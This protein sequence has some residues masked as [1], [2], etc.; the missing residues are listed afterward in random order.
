VR[1]NGA[2]V[3]SYRCYFLDIA[4]HLAASQAIECEGDAQVQARADALL[5]GSFHAGIEVWQLGRSGCGEWTG[6]AKKVSCAVVGG[7]PN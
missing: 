6:Q 2:A 5:A 4:N 7:T 1:P 3:P